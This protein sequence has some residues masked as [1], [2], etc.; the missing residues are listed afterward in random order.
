MGYED[1]LNLYAYVRNDPLNQTDPSG[2]CVEDLCIGEAIVACAVSAPCAAGAIA[3]TVATGLAIKNAWDHLT[4]QN[5]QAD[6]PAA[7]PPSVPGAAPDGA[8]VYPGSGPSGRPGFTG[9]PG[10]WEVGPR[11][12]RKYGEDGYPET[13]VDYPGEGGRH[14]GESPHA[15]DWGRPDGGGPPTAEDRGQ[16]RPPTP[17]ERFTEPSRD[18]GGY[19]PPDRRPPPR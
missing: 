2:R 15:Q 17:E 19:L 4:N 6:P 14:G 11:G 13:D 3:L 18:P 1:D 16:Q 8:P 12:D 9:E 7:E 5:E 10:S